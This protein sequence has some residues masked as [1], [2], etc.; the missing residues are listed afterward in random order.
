MTIA[1]NSRLQFDVAAFARE[2]LGF[3]PGP[4]QVP[5]LDPFI[6]RGILNCC[7][8]WGKSTVVAVLAVHHAVYRPGSLTVVA[9]PSAR[10]SGEFVRKA[11]G[12]L[13]LLEIPVKGD[14]DNPISLAFPNGSR[15]VGLPG[16]ESTI[17]GFSNVSLLLIDEASRVPDSLYQALRPMTATNAHA[18]IWLMSTPNGRQGFFYDAWTQGRPEWTRIA[19]P[20]TQ[21]PRIGA[22]F[23]DD[24][25]CHLTDQT[26][27]QEYLCEFLAADYAYFDP[28]AIDDAF[29]PRED[30]ISHDL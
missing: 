6:R 20:A 25:R 14:G 24:E 15:I 2:R 29:R 11:G 27:R 13:R 18:A 30:R 23:L 28:E 3:E 22:K 7:R 26:F 12:F 21:C 5:A 19:A 10:Q 8:Q 16:R 4:D 1:D 9:S 17:R